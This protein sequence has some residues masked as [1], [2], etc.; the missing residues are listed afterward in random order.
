MIQIDG[1]MGEGGGQ[2]LR[3]ALSLSIITG[4]PVGIMNIRQGRSK[5][6]LMAQHLKAVEAAAKISRANMEGA[7]LGST[8]LRFEPGEIRSG[9]YRFAIGTAG[10]TL[11]VLQT[12]FV[13]LSLASSASSIILYGGTHVPWSPSFHYA[14]LMWLPTLRRM[15]FDAQIKLDLAGFYPPGGGRISATI[16]PAAELRPLALTQR[17]AGARLGGISAVANLP[18]SI[19]E[20]QKRQTILR[21]EAVRTTLGLPPARVHTLQLPAKVKG[22]FL[23][24]LAEFEK[25]ACCYT[26]LG[27][28]HKPAERVADE[29]VDALLK[30]V[31]SGGAIDQYLADQVLLPLSLVEGESRFHTCQVTSHLTTNAEVL[32]AFL[33]VEIDIQGE[34]GSPGLVRIRASGIPGRQQSNHPTSSRPHPGYE[35]PA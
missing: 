11:L 18:M 22:T 13:P 19:A 21:L 25:S 3:T 15:G 35:R 23:L 31:E 32:R 2:V 10:S 14:D 29:A 24:L 28:L 16:R 17:G 7:A 20:R 4:Q 9:R 33:P 27:E 34:E 30:F 12:I 26:G 6:G 1:S 5:P 8:Q